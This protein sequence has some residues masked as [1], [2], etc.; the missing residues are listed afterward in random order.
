MS[1]TSYLYH[2]MLKA[3]S[4]KQ[5]FTFHFLYKFLADEHLI[6]KLKRFEL[7]LTN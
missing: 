1:L 6:C 7:V 4:F 5:N 2:L 3:Q